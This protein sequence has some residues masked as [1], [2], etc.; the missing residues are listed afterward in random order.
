MQFILYGDYVDISK[1]KILN[2]SSQQIN[3]DNIIYY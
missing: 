1:L 3:Y 2:E